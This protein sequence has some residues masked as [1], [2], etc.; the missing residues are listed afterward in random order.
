[1]RRV[2]PPSDGTRADFPKSARLLRRGDFLR[3]GRRGR[4]F[5]LSDLVVIAERRHRRGPRLG[6]TVGRS[7]GKAVRRN[8]AKRLLR[9]YFSA[10]PLALRVRARSRGDRAGRVR[11]DRS[12]RGGAEL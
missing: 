5:G 12:F 10:K 7:A 1:M 8:R 6:I 2:T 11:V 9:E 4:R 3:V